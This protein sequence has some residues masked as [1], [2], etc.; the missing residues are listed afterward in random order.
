MFHVEPRYGPLFAQYAS[1]RKQRDEGL[2]RQD[3]RTDEVWLRQL[4]P[5]GE[6][7]N[8]LRLVF[9]DLLTAALQSVLTDI[10]LPG[11]HIGLRYR[12]GWQP[13]QSL[14]E[15]LLAARE[16]DRKQRRTTVGP[17]RYDLSVVF[18]EES[19]VRR[20][21]LGQL[22]FALIL[23]RLAQVLMV[24]KTTGQ[25]PVLLLDDFYSE[26]DDRNAEILLD[27]LR[28]KGY[29]VLLTDQGTRLGEHAESTVFYVE[30]GALIER[31]SL[32]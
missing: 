14:L 2:R 3:F 28:T 25:T 6:R 13:N 31:P 20:L 9:V 12:R 7:L 8:E 21:S 22:K 30:S 1:I 4:A 19:E 23:I 16:G 29:Q 27:Y 15:G 32:R 24:S 17:H 26:L 5:V 11:T 18:Q 10:G